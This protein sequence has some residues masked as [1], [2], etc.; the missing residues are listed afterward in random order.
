LGP[1]YLG[2]C[3][4]NTNGTGDAYEF[5]NYALSPDKLPGA[6]NDVASIVKAISAA[7]PLAHATLKG[8]S[9]AKDTLR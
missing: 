8:T 5:T 7:N 9:D 3:P 2:P 4:N 1:Q 6:V